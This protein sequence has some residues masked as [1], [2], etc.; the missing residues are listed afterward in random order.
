MIQPG[1]IWGETK[2]QPTKRLLVLLAAM[3]AVLTV[4]ILKARA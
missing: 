4:F 1:A 3:F 2:F